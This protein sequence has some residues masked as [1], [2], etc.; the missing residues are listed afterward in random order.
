MD[1]RVKERGKKKRSFLTLLSLEEEGWEK[2]RQI[3][4]KEGRQKLPGQE[5][6]RGGKK[7]KNLCSLLKKRRKK[8]GAG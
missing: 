7:R 6:V 4:R 1:F 5:G 2:S 8:G 3:Q